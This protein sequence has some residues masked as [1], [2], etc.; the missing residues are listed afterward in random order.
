MAIDYQSRE[1]NI[2]SPSFW[3]KATWLKGG[4][5]S[6]MMSKVAGLQPVPP[7]LGQHFILGQ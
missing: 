2:Y 7:Q 3:L 6:W 4:Y 1:K 5:D